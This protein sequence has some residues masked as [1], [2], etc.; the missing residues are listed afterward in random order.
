MV[1]MNTDTGQKDENA[2]ASPGA[3]RA[4]RRTREQIVEIL[5]DFEG[6]GLTQEAFAHDRGINVG[7]LRMWL[8]KARREEA[9]REVVGGCAPAL[10][11]LRL[12][13]GVGEEVRAVRIALPNGVE[14]HLGAPVSVRWLEQ[15][16]RVL[17]QC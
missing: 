7:T 13:G 1:G 2:T 4:K 3:G 6:S 12:G 14:L 17:R 16:L 10:T 9:R 15:L 11:E 5:R 8:A